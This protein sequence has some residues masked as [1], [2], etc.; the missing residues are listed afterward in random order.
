MS[1]TVGFAGIGKVITLA[2]TASET[3]S[4]ITATIAGRAATVTNPTGLDYQA[5]I[6]VQSGDVQGPTTFSIAYADQVNNAGV[7][8]TTVT[9][10][11]SVTIG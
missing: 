4:V 5:T 11:S 2:F 6:T 9:D 3:L 10:A 7:I 1:P 8:G